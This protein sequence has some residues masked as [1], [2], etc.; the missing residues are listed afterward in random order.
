MLNRGILDDN[1][2]SKLKL[3]IIVHKTFNLF[4]LYEYKPNQVNSVNIF[5]LK[6]WYLKIALLPIGYYAFKFKKSISF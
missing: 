6:E 5:A 1:A 4:N 2:F 3:A